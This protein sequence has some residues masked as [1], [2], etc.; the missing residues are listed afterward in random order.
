MS[1]RLVRSV[2]RLAQ[3]LARLERHTAAEHGVSVSQ[4]RVMMSLT[5]A[6]GG[7]RISDLAH[8][9]GLAVSTMTRNLSLLER[10]GWIQREIGRDDRRTVL[11]TLTGDGRD[12]SRRLQQSTLG[13]F[14]R[15]FRA[16]HPTD[17]VER[18]VALDRVAA[19]LEKVQASTGS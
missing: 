16:F 6:P 8:E 4:L 5:H 15:A 17:R 2:Q 9:Q 19:A 3:A 1:E 11:V 7:I 10:K 14:G 13:I 12:V 18:A